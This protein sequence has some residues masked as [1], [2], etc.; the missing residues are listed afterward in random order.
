MPGAMSGGRSCGPLARASA[1]ERANSLAFSGGTLCCQAASIRA[2]A[3][4]CSLRR[5]R[6]AFDCLAKFTVLAAHGC[7]RLPTTWGQYVPSDGDPAG[8]QLPPRQSRAA[9]QAVHGQTNATAPSITGSNGEVRANGV[10]P[11]RPLRSE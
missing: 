6:S 11:V 2:T 10:S 9:S 5:A 8:R 3:S 1:T 4:F 7:G